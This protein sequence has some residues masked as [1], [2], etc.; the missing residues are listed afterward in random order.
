MLFIEIDLSNKEG[1]FKSYKQQVFLWE[2]EVDEQT[3]ENPVSKTDVTSADV[4]LE[5]VD[6]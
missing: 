4:N 6:I 3:K 2:K 1:E 5:V